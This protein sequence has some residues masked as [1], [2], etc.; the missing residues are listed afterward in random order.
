MYTWHLSE[1]LWKQIIIEI[2]IHPE[3]AAQPDGKVLSLDPVPFLKKMIRH[4]T[5]VVRKKQALL[6]KYVFQ[7]QYSIEPY[8]VGSS[9]PLDENRKPMMDAYDITMDRVMG[10]HVGRYSREHEGT[11][12]EKWASQLSL[13]ISQNF[14]TSYTGPKLFYN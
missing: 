10:M 7:L 5:E 11:V 1:D 3:N 4:N 2:P 13:L 6:R 14:N 9:W 8:K 12:D